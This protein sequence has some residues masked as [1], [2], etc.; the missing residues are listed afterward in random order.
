MAEYEINPGMRRPR[1]LV[2]ENSKGEAGTVEAPPIW[3]MSDQALAN[4]P[5]EPDG[6]S[7]FVEHNGATG[8]LVVKSSADGDI[9]LGK[10]LITIEDTFHMRPPFGATGGSSNVG[11]EEPIPGA[12]PIPAPG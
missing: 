8:T 1:N 6:M 2:F 9:G 4:M 12:E 3:E 11:E 7:G 10:K 5:V